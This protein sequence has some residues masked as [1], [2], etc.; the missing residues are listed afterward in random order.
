MQMKAPTSYIFT[1]NDSLLVQH[2]PPGLASLTPP[3]CVHGDTKK[4]SYGALVPGNG[5][6]QGGRVMVGG[7]IHYHDGTLISK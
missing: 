3:S 7:Q 1:G 5:R 6:H 2:R 4:E